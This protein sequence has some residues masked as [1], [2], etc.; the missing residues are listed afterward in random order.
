MGLARRLPGLPCKALLLCNAKYT[1]PCDLSSTAPGE[2]QPRPPDAATVSTPLRGR[3]HNALRRLMPR[4]SCW[5][6]SPAPQPR[7]RRGRSCSRRTHP[8]LAATRCRSSPID[9]ARS[10]R[11]RPRPRDAFGFDPAIIA[12][13]GRTK[14]ASLTEVCRGRPSGASMSRRLRVR[15]FPP[16]RRPQSERVVG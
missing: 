8:R 7:N 11:R 6:V 13:Y 5:S 4:M 16:Q 2:P 15:L 1:G 14:Q 3:W 12:R 9:P 10:V